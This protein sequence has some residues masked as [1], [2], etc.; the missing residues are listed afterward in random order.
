MIPFITVSVVESALIAD[1]KNHTHHSSAMK[2][3]IFVDVF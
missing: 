3:Y 2:Y 1:V